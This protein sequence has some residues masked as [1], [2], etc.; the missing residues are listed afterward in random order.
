MAFALLLTLWTSRKRINRKYVHMVSLLAGGYGFV[1][2]YYIG[3]ASELALS[4]VLIG[5][6]WGSILSMPYAMLS[7]TIDPKRMGV[8]MGIFNMFIVIPQIVAAFAI[9]P[10]YKTFFG[11]A[12]INAM[13]LAGT[14]LV[15]AGLANFL[16][17]DRKAVTYTP[18]A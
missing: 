14:S 17:T 10:A 6:S 5:F 4:F 7:S 2:M 13:L 9:T 1:K 12:P 16:I 8:Y 3:D 15:L 11:E 18:E